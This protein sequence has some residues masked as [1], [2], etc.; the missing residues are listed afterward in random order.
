MADIILRVTPEELQK[1]AGEITSL[2]DKIDRRFQSIENISTKT[3]GYWRGDAGEKDREG[4]A[5]YK[6]DIAFV[7]KRLREHPDDLQKMA[8]IYK[9]G[10]T[11]VEQVANSLRVDQIP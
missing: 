4:Y 6:D 7:L 2:V 11:Y 9:E 1:K 3:R 10:E 5:S 8:G